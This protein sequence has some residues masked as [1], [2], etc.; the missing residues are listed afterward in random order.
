MR[1]WDIVSKA[2]GKRG[3]EMTRHWIAAI[4]GDGIG[5]EVLPEGVRVVE[6]AAA[7]FGIDIEIEHFDWACADYYRKITTGAP[8]RLRRHSLISDGPIDATHLYAFACREAFATLALPQ[9][10]P[11][12]M[13]SG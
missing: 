2:V 8:Q 13:R 3:D 1:S 12:L 6:I 4:A 5:T 7:A 9:S 11:G 10:E